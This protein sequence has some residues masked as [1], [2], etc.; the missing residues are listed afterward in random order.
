M[1]NNNKIEFVYLVRSVSMDYDCVYH[2]NPTYNNTD[3][4]LL[5]EPFPVD[6]KM[7]DN[8]NVNAL[9]IEALEKKV[10]VMRA[11]STKSINKVLSRIQELKALPAS[12]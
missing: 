3:L 1:I 11:E 10:D 9:E 2:F 5:A 8:I 6:F 7:R 4:I 12:I